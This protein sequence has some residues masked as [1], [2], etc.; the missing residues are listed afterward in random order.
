MMMMMT[1]CLTTDLQRHGECMAGA[2]HCVPGTVLRKTK[3]S[4][5]TKNK[6]RLYRLN[7]G[8]AGAYTTHHA[9]TIR[10]HSIDC[11][12]CDWALSSHRHGDLYIDLQ[13]DSPCSYLGQQDRH[14]DACNG[15]SN[16]K[17]HPPPL[18]L[19][20]ITYIFFPQPQHLPNFLIATYFSC[21][22]AL[23]QHAPSRAHDKSG[24]AS[25]S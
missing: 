5:V 21:R 16:V 19:S 4:Q 15:G 23:E 20:I 2:Q 24:P 17:M 25:V 3:S 18:P 12:K 7:N 6:E 10:R 11:V 8:R 14:T 1:T 9:R 22:Q 13:L